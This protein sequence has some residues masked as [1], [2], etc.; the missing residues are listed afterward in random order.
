MFSSLALIWS[1]SFWSDALNCS[2]YCFKVMSSTLVQTN[3]WCTYFN[4]STR[5]SV[6]C[7]KSWITMKVK[8]LVLSLRSFNCSILACYSYTSLS[9]AWVRI[10]L[11]IVCRIFSARYCRTVTLL[12]E[13]YPSM[14]SSE[15]LEGDC[16]EPI[17][18]FW[19]SWR[20]VDD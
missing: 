3:I 1:L 15:L 13:M 19:S 17:V 10:S 7:F 20:I 18:P 6:G 2:F 9:T 16:F 5:A 4:A 12:S 14:L 8:S 11:R